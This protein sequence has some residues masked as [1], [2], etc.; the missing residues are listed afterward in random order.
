M[1]DNR[2]N[3]EQNEPQ[4]NLIIWLIFG[5]SVDILQ[6]IISVTTAGIPIIG[7]IF[8]YL[9]TVVLAIIFYGVFWLSKK[10]E[11][12]GLILI[13]GL[14]IELIPVANLFIWIALSIALMW[15]IESIG[16]L[17]KS[18]VKGEI[19]K[20]VKVAVKKTVQVLAP[21]AAPAIEAASTAMQAVKAAAKS[22]L[23]K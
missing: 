9:V 5:L 10:G 6:I 11:A 22:K 3:Q 13:G 14:V 18:A 4:S 20:L 15:I 16:E 12:H 21:E 23:K 8:G 19:K 1:A 17:L 7:W 2:E